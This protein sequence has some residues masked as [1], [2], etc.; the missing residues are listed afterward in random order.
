MSNE[1]CAVRAF[2]YNMV[3]AVNKETFCQVKVG[4]CLVAR[5]LTLATLELARM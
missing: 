2:G 1:V 3:D 5:F 4:R